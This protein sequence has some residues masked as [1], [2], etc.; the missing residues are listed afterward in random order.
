M[1]SLVIRAG[2]IV[3]NYENRKVW[4]VREA[5]LYQLVAP[6]VMNPCYSSAEQQLS[7]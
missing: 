7:V 1:I 2:F 3:H 6:L 4:L 5:R